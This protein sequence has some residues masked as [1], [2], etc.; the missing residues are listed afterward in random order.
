LSVHVV[1]EARAARLL[2]A[3]PYDPQ[4]LRLRG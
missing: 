3:P 4:G 1:G 2:S